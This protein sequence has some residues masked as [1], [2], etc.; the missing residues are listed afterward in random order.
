MNAITIIKYDKQSKTYRSS[1][2]EEN[3]IFRIASI[4]A[5]GNTTY[6]QKK[7]LG[8]VCLCVTRSRARTDS[9]EIWETRPSTTCF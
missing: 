7:G 6:K 2:S 3:N 4:V 5:N 1:S 9:M 8:N